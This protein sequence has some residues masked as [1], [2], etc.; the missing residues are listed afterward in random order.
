MNRLTL[1]F[2][3]L[4]T[5]SSINLIFAQSANEKDNTW[6]KCSLQKSGTGTHGLPT[7]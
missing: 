6:T 2:S 5:M 3:Y 7:C 1:L 4:L